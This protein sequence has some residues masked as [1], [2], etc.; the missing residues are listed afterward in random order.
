MRIDLASE[1]TPWQGLGWRMVEAQHKVATMGLVGGSPEAQT[2]LE[3]ILEDS[4]PPLPHEAQN[5]HWLLFTPFRYTPGQAG[6]RFRRRS[7]P[8]VFYGAEERATALAEAG[9]WRLRFWCDSRGLQATQHSM[10]VTLFQFKA[11]AQRAIHLNAAPFAERRA[12]WTHPHDYTHTQACA[13]QARKAG[14][15]LIRYESVRR[16]D[17]NCLAILTPRVFQHA[18]GAFTGN[19]QGW[20]LHLLPPHKIAF[21]RT[22]HG[23]SQVFEFE[24]FSDRA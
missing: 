22:L 8:G 18:G 16:S 6:S 20:T 3:E 7:D 5:L 13:V 10:P 21:Q 9:Y 17:G 2:L 11:N 14:V 4:K 1:A 24:R 15:D 12:D 19:Q 23:E